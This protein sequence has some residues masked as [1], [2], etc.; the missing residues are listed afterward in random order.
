M[1]ITKKIHVDG[2]V[3]RARCMPQNPDMVA[4]KTSGLEVYVFNCGK[5]PAGADGRSCNP[6]LRLKGHEKEGYGLSWSPFKQG[7]LVSGSND[8][9]VCLWDVSASAEDKVLSAMHVFEVM[10][11][12]IYFSF[13]QWKILVVYPL[14]MLLPDF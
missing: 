1:E 8:C 4:A 14:C 3:N 7:Y 5:P 13:C 11:G 9:K 2:E 6:D 10:I 12:F